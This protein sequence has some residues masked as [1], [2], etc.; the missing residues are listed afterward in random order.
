MP[1]SKVEKAATLLDNEMRINFS[2]LRVRL[3]ITTKDIRALDAATSLA[4]Q[5]AVRCHA[6]TATAWRCEG[7]GAILQLLQQCIPFMSTQREL[8]EAVVEFLE[9]DTTSSMF[10]AMIK[11]WGTR[12][13]RRPGR[14]RGAMW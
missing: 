11:V 6:G 8:A 1:K 7:E 3:H 13:S 4:G 5:S 9:A 14:P 10:N 2:N 12:E